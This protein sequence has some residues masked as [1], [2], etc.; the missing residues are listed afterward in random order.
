MAFTGCIN[1]KENTRVEIRTRFLL[2]QECKYEESVKTFQ[3]YDKIKAP[4][5]DA[6]EV[7]AQP[8]TCGGCYE[9]RT[10]TCVY[11]NSSLEGNALETIAAMIKRTLEL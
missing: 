7:A 4:D 6:R 11:V 8:I 2:T 5:A 10:K 3:P 1:P 9:P